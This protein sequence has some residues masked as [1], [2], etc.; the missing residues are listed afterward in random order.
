[1]S[2]YGGSTLHYNN[3][4]YIY[5][6]Y[7]V[8]TTGARVKRFGVTERRSS[9]GGGVVLQFRPCV[10]RP[11]RVYFGFSACGSIGRTRVH[12][13]RIC[14][15]ERMVGGWRRLVRWWRNGANE[16]EVYALHVSGGE[17]TMPYSGGGEDNWIFTL[18]VHT[19]A[20]IMPRQ[21]DRPVPYI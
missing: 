1:M 9:V 4:V 15:Y 7:T 8:I 21:N 2:L 20:F 3:K 11:P 14:I 17:G 5:N 18:K 12:C 19:R 6:I 13:A 10:T 16:R